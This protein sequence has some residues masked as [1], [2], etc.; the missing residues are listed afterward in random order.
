MLM[1]DLSG[2]FGT[3]DHN[4][5]LERLSQRFFST[6]HALEWFASYLSDGCQSSQR[7]LQC[8]VSQGC[9]LGPDCLPCVP[10]YLLNAAAG[11]VTLTGNREHITPILEGLHWLLVEQ[12]VIVKILVITYK[13]LNNLAPA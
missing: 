2:A 9:V 11:V 12:C 3:V 4:I 8:G 13:V 7:S 5:L 1:L 6:R 10:V